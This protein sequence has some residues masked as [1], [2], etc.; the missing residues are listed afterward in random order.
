[1]NFRRSDFTLTRLPNGTVLAAGGY[2]NPSSGVY[3]PASLASA[4]VYNPATGTWSPTG[5]MAYSRMNHTATLLPSGKVLVVGGASYADGVFS[6]PSSAEL[7]DPITGQWS[8]VYGPSTARLLH[9]ATLLDDGRVLIAGGQLESAGLA[10][11]MIY[12]PVSNAWS[13]T[14]S[15]TS[16]RRYHSA[17]RIAGGK[18]LAAYGWGASS[19]Y[20]AGADLFDPATGTW[21]AV[22]SPYSGTAKQTA[23]SLPDGRAIFAA[24]EGTATARLYDAD[25]GSWSQSG[26][27]PRDDTAG[28]VLGDGR[29]L[30]IGGSEGYPG[31]KRVEV[32]DPGT[33]TW[34]SLTQLQSYRDK[35]EAVLLLD[36]RVLIAG[37]TNSSSAELYQLECTPAVCPAASC[38]A[39]P[40]GC[41]G[42]LS[43]G[44]CAD[45][46]V[47]ASNVCCAPTT[48]AAAGLTCGTLSDGCG[49]VLSC[50]ACGTGQVCRAG[51]CC[52][53][54][55][56]AAG[57]TCG[58]I[59]DGCGGTVTCGTCP[60]GQACTGN[61]CVVDPGMATYDASLGVP[62]CA[63]LGPSCD[64]GSL[65]VGR[66]TLGPEPGAP[67]TIARSCLDGTG[68]SFHRDESLDRL[69]IS[70]VEG[71]P[72]ATGRAARIEA[73]VWAYSGY[74]SDKLDLYAAADAANPVWTFL[75]TLTPTQTGAQVLSLTYT[76]PQG[77]A[78]QAIRGTFRF[79]AN[80]GACTTGGYDDHDDLAF[81]VELPVD[82]APPVVGLTAPALDATLSGTVALVA[83]ATDD[84][85]VVRVEFRDA[86]SLLGSV[87]GPP[88]SWSWNTRASANGAH[89]LTAVAFD[90]SGKSTASSPVPVIV[91]N[92]LTPPLVSLAAPA[93][94]A[95]VSGAVA[96]TASA[97]DDVGV[98]RVEFSCDGK[99]VGTATTAP[100][101]VSWNTVLVA[102]G[103]HI[104][105]AIAADAAGNTATSAAVSVTVANAAA[106][107][108]TAV[109]DA[110]RRAPACATAAVGCDTAALVNGRSYGLGPEPNT[111][112][113][114]QT[115]CVDGSY[116]SYHSDESVDRIRV[117]SVD[118]GPLSAGRAVRVEV[119]V[120]AWSTVDHLDVYFTG[121]ADAPSWTLAGTVAPI[122]SG[123]QTL[124]VT[125]TLPAGAVQAVRANFRYSSTP[126]PC[127]AG[128]YDDRDDLAFAV[129]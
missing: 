67:N 88:W 105:T 97:S 10:S 77:A 121:N 78:V 35:P 85:G 19:G 118:G 47:C 63:Q 11:A 98:A 50:G 40:D 110:L 27:F 92:D 99:L 17:A 81:A 100:Y 62:R 29:A 12:D 123:A 115:S 4:E 73:T 129:Q 95:Q 127:T 60:A 9:T 111:P 2:G 87:T 36:G 13:A 3:I 51:A 120:W 39:M 54:L 59:A 75:G 83:S 117:L 15:M 45:G 26:Y 79:S 91:A 44:T 37:A 108:Q 58:S 28:V 128:G 18:V 68:G 112:N 84:V 82:A 96:L 109:Y 103:S 38:G 74:A 69:R 94:G 23:F 125:Y 46:Q 52:T 24:G 72:L 106:A 86:G 89:T 30:L 16:A 126:G 1:M 53:L 49:G 33:V 43:C 64:S 8:I 66:A 93:A 31:S 70:S 48:C 122:A 34:T 56:C 102:N 107:V 6:Y 76:V 22:A 42:T 25:T 14:G 104:L 124:T 57:T 7:Y 80:P 119:T 71:G 21:T 65:L 90:A 116:G 61:T 32:F 20:A 114:L 101:T 41:G 113:T 55:A 5:N